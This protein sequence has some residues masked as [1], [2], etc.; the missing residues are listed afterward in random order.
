[1]N[2]PAERR[3]ARRCRRLAA[4]FALACV[5]L[6]GVPAGAVTPPSMKAS[7]HAIRMDGA[8]VTEAL[9]SIA[10]A[11]GLRLQATGTLRGRLS[12]K[13]SA[14]SGAALL[15][16]LASEHAFTWFVHGGALYVS[17]AGDVVSERIQVGTSGLE[18]AR[19]TLTSMQLFE[20]RFGWAEVPDDGAV[21]VVGPPDYVRLVKQALRPMA[22]AAARDADQRRER[23]RE[24]G[25]PVDVMVFRLVH[26][27]ADDRTVSIRGRPVVMPGMATILRNA[28]G[29]GGAGRGGAGLPGSL[30][31]RPEQ[32]EEAVDD[33]REFDR[34][35]A[36]RA[37]RGSASALP[38][39]VRDADP[40]RSAPPRRVR[41]EADPRINAVLVVDVPS[42]RTYYERLIASL[43]VPQ[44]LVEIEALIVD[45]DR[46]L[47]GELGVEWTVSLPRF[48]A[49][50]VP[51]ATTS[52][53]A[54]TTFVIPD[55]N[56]FFARLRALDTNGDAAILA[57]PSVLTLENQPAVL[58]L[59]A[60]Q[61]IRLVGERAVDVREVTA[62]TLLKVVP[63]IHPAEAS[64]SVQL[65]VDIEDGTID[66]AVRGDVPS[67]RRNTINTQAVIELGQ[68]LVVGG[69]RASQQRRDVAKVP[70]LGDIP[71]VG[72]LFRSRQTV[73]R[74]MERLFILT[75]RVV[76][77]E[78]RFDAAAR[79]P[80]QPQVEAVSRRL[81]PSVRLEDL[82]GDPGNRGTDAPSTDG[83][84]G[85]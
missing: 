43:D 59:S 24:S 50:T 21:Q 7:P 25:Q 66:P 70:V 81:Q 51:R 13:Q 80:L 40:L 12:G 44:R 54:S 2:R 77:A 55:V 60:S 6:H 45:I 20:D 53:A 67:V 71:L 52:A 76:G 29:T 39:P 49:T 56:R 83:A 14:N 27:N 75:P 5:A 57:K 26:A 36:A 64:T 19:A 62:G 47:L 82:F 16:R 30:T 78:T 8:T 32:F 17:P 42:R 74:N 10:G 63:R 38:L 23:Q 72:G 1:M 69:Y 18:A 48:G 37:S 41:I 33:A 68:S 84:V 28:L 22:E 73:D 46:N 58:D 11:Y 65:M 31:L 15:D 61:F 4:A 34:Q 85:R 79:T 3:A 9:A 35:V